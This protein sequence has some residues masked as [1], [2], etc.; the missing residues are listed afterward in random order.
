MNGF[1]VI[2]WKSLRSLTAVTD[3]DAVCAIREQYAVLRMCGRLPIVPATFFIAPVPEIMCVGPT[4]PV[5][6]VPHEPS[7]E[8]EEYPSLLHFL[9]AIGACVTHVSAASSVAKRQCIVAGMLDA[10]AVHVGRHPEVCS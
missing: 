6:Y 3:Y 2:A 10:V 1:D 8:R 4:V 5:Y 9:V 7:M